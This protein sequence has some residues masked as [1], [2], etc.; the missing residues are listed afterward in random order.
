MFKGSLHRQGGP[1]RHNIRPEDRLAKRLFAA[2]ASVFAPDPA[3][4]LKA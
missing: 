1:I 3:A 4:A 2:G